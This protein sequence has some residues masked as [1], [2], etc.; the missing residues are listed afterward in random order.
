[1]GIWGS[2]FCAT[3]SHYYKEIRP[4]VAGLAG[5]A[6]MDALITGRNND[7]VK[8]HPFKAAQIPNFV[9]GL[10]EHL[11]PSTPESLHAN[12]SIELLD[13]GMSCNL[14]IYPLLRQGRDVDII[15]AFDASADIRK[16]NWL[17]VADGY[18]LQRGVRGWPMGSGWPDKVAEEGGELTADAKTVKSK[19]KEL[20]ASMEANKTREERA[21]SDLGYCTIWVGSAEERASTHPPPT[22]R[23]I[24]DEDFELSDA[25]SSGIAVAYFPLLPNPLVPGVDPDKSEFLSTW[26]FVYTHDQI[27]QVAALA[28]NNFEAGQ[29]K[30]KA[31]VRAMWKRKKAMREEKDRERV[32]RWRNLSQ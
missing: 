15:I 16:E 24:D 31:L 5:F 28:R 26:N 7:L 3:L 13:A 27:D 18:A 14:P 10:R 11:P 29:V 25:S 1:M 12:E 19:G 22:S 30:V 9:L 32:E 23:R 4:V 17:R 8:V 2:A 21:S 6:G 20:E